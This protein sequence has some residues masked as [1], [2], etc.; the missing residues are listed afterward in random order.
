MSTSKKQKSEAVK[1][2]EKV[3]GGSLTLARLL[4]SIR[5][6]EDETLEEFSKRLGVSRQH[7]C[8]IEKERKVVSPERAAKFAKILGYSKEQ[9]VALALQALVDDAEL[10]LKV[11]V[12]AA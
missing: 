9:F 8:D 4:N 7:L 5:R 3:T 1:F 6:S 12:K 10:D 11:E 2:L